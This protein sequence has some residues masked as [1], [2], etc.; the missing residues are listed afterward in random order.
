LLAVVTTLQ[1]GGVDLLH[2]LKVLGQA[3]I[4][5]GVVALLGTKVMKRSSALLDAPVDAES[6][7]AISLAI[8]LGLAAAAAYFGLAAIIGAFLAGMILAETEH[9]KRLEED[10]RPIMG[11][12]LPFFFVITGSQVNL[13]LL[14]NW[15]MVGTVAFVTLL[16]VVSKIVGG[17]LGARSLGIKSAT[18]VGVGMVPRGEVGIIVASL[19]KQAGVFGASTYAIVIAMSLLTS[20]IAPPALKALFR[21]STPDKVDEAGPQSAGQPEAG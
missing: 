9:R 6:P 19:G 18:I 15:Q 17:G 20:V 21:G 3:L 7:L 12:L 2:I 1:T 8:C 10:V 5:L 14:S 4:F 13:G 16:A 11:F